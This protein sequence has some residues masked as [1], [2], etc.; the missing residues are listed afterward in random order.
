MKKPTKKSRPAKA[1]GQTFPAGWDEERVRRV[2]EHYESQTEEEAVAE[3]EAAFQ[4]EGQT[5]MVVPTD[6]VPAIRKLIAR[7]RGA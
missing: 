6:L 3:D 7:R 2:L 4:A 1:K 5:V